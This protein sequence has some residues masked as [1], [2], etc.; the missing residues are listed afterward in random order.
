MQHSLLQLT[1]SG[2]AEIIDFPHHESYGVF[3]R[4]FQIKLKGH[5]VHASPWH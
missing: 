3:Y 4:G 5:L 1:V 2:L